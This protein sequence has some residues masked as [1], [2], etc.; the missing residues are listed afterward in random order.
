MEVF[1]MENESQ[2]RRRPK[3]ERQDW[4]PHWILKILYGIWMFCFGAAKIAIGAVATVLMIVL[5]CGFV[6]IG[7][8]GEYLES[9]VLP[10]S[11]NYEITGISDLERLPMF[12]M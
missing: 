9:D 6:F 12:I 10:E 5:V 1:T 3:R 7:I 8:L 4:N 11:V 2:R